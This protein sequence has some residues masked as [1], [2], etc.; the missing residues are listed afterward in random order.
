[1]RLNLSRGFSLIEVIVAMAIVAILAAI[2]LPSY[3]VYVERSNRAVARSA[4]SEVVS[5]QE[6]WYLDRKRYATSLDR[7]GWGGD[8]LFLDREGSLA[9]TSTAQSI[10]RVSL[11]GN[12]A[13]LAC[14]PGGAVSASGFSVVAEPIGAQTSDTRCATLCLS[15]TGIKSASGSESESCWSR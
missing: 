9:A 2:A 12:P 11:E 4:L 15:S 5:R 8:P 14:P 10:Y 6:S 3:R 1:M 7:L 13:S